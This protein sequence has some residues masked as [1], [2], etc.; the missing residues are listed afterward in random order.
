MSDTPGNVVTRYAPSPTGYQHVGGARTALFNWLLARRQGGTYLLRVE[1]TDLARSTEQA[2]HQL[3]DDLHWLGLQWDNAELVVQSERVQVYNAIIDDLMRRELAY[4]AY[5]TPAELD[6]MRKEAERH[7][8]QFLYRRRNIPADQAARWKAEGRPHVV[9]FAMPTREYRFRDEVLGEIVLPAEEAQDFVIRKGDGMPTYHFAVVVDDAAMKITHVLRGQEHVKNTFN[10][11][12][13]QEALGYPRPT[14][15]HLTTIQNPDGSKMGKRDRDKAVRQRAQEWLKSAKKTAA[16]LS[17]ATGLPETQLS[18]WLGNSKKQLDLPEHAAL[19]PVIGLRDADLPEILV[20]DFRKNGY[21]PEALLNFLALLGW[22]PGG[23]RERM[24][25]EEMV[26]LFSLDRVGKSN[27]KFDRGKLLA[28]NT[29]ALAAA[30][31]ER[32]LAGFKDFLAANP[33][34]PLKRADDAAL[35]RVLAMKKGFRL[36]REVEEASRFLFVEDAQIVYQ[37]DAVEKVLKKGDGQG[38]TVLR[39]VRAAL[40]GVTDWTAANLD[41][42]VNRYCEQ[43]GLGLGKVA[44]PIR[45]AVSGGTISPPIFESLEM[46]GRDPTL[47]RIDR[48]LQTAGV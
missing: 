12:A 33:D 7:K 37:P 26:G 47:R 16:D 4:K 44:Q 23:D 17:G 41:A 9:R 6:A 15:A 30:T 25:L 35:S 2:V 48:C 21:L 14:Y 13:L 1:D 22:S 27:P 42:A 40:E 18:A 34:S 45:V 8:R 31:P 20:H 38:L 36:F 10:H 19:M 24:T 43:K 29:E 32:L 3:L 39:E 11:I 5:E 28:F 46:L